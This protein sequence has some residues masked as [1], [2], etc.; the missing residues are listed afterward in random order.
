MSRAYL[1]LNICCSGR[2]LKNGKKPVFMR[3]CGGMAPSVQRP[4]RQETARFDNRYP[5]LEDTATKPCPL[6]H[7]RMIWGNS[8]YRRSIPM[9]AQVIA[10]VNQKGGVGKS[11]SCVNL[12]VG[13]AQAG[14]KSC[15][16]TV[17]L[18]AVFPSAWAIPSRTSCPSP[19][20][21]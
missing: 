2:F 1:S 5:F 7:P 9:N 10:L 15:W 14:K 20:L 18:K 3:V 11:T 12:G 17:I 6:F 13:L 19:C 21:T 8:D 16:W 4:Q